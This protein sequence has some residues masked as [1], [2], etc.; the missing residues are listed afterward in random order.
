MYSS[1]HAPLRTIAMAALRSPGAC[2]LFRHA[3]GTP[4]ATS[5]STWSFISA[6]SGETTSARRGPAVPS[7]TN[8]GAWKQ[9]DLPPPVG[10][11]STLSRPWRI[12]SMA[13][14]C[15]GRNSRIAPIAF[16]HLN[17]GVSGDECHA[18]ANW[19]TRGRSSTAPASVNAAQQESGPARSHPRAQKRASRRNG[20]VIMRGSGTQSPDSAIG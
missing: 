11:T 4:L 13:S 3:A 14:R 19:R 10:S 17:D 15:Q 6:I 2:A 1:R 16:E 12:A 9:R 20:V 7:S 18:A 8:A 5:P